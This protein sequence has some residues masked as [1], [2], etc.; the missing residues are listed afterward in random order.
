MAAPNLAIRLH[1]EPVR[2][3]AYTSVG[4]GYMG[5]GTAISNPARQFFVQNLTDVT[6]MF[7]FDGVNDHFPLPANGFFLDDITSNKT[8]QGGFWLAEG[9]RLY[10]KEVG[11]PS[12]GSVYFTVAY[13]TDN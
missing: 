1:F 2:S 13:G 5:V 6:L 8:Q 7:S 10:V 12:S 11:T 9:T 4:S 3:L